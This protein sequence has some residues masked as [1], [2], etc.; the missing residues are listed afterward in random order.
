M[1]S[2][3]SRPDEL[4]SRTKQIKT[5]CGRVYATVGVDVERDSIYEIILV[6]GKA[7]T[8]QKANMEVVGRLCTKSLQ[9]GV[10]V[11]AITKQ[12]RGIECYKG[13]GSAKGDNITCWHQVAEF[14]DD[15][16]KRLCAARAILAGE[17]GSEN[18]ERAA[19]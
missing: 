14:I 11:V 8:C 18:S 1:S 16:N 13:G 19:G 3:R 6:L 9:Y 5:A 7:G 2:E 15:E 12:M 4:Q 10:P 17:C